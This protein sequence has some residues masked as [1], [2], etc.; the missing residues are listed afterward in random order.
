MILDQSLLD[1]R[2]VRSFVAL[3]EEKHFGRAAERIG[4]SQSA[5]SVQLAALEHQLGCKLFD[6]TSRRVELNAA[7]EQVLGRCRQ[8]LLLMEELV[9][10]VRNP[11]KRYLGVL[12][13]GYGTSLL[14]GP[15]LSLLRQ[16][17]KEPGVLRLELVDLS[18]E[19]MVRMLHDGAL[20]LAFLHPPVASRKL[21]LWSLPEERMVAVL[22]SS[23]G[24]VSGSEFQGDWLQGCPLLLPP[25]IE[26]PRLV[27][28]TLEYL[29]ASQVNFVAG[30]EVWQPQQVMAMVAAGMGA[31]FVMSGNARS[32]PEGVTVHP[33]PESFPR[34]QCAVAA[35][36]GAARGSLALATAIRCFTFA[37]LPLGAEHDLKGETCNSAKPS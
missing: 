12:R 3:A 22:P 6:R 32:A 14:F 21:R 8:I 36:A 11:E 9:D 35:V 25:R 13:I 19:Q 7:G 34:V 2:L 27:D 24:Y 31:G 29:D 23:F 17:A 20:D 5:L 28:A 15:V 30:Q 1:G 37:E 10:E 18:T 26:A 33:L 16:L 4:I